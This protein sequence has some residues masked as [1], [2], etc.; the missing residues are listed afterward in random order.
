MARQIIIF[1]LT[2]E[3]CVV[4]M[5]LYIPLFILKLMWHVYCR[6]RTLLTIMLFGK[7][8]SAL[9]SSRVVRGEAMNFCPI[10]FLSL[11][12]YSIS[13]IPLYCSFVY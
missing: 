11:C 8:V 3:R 4:Y 9:L 1:V 2:L 13:T 12:S 6:I 10:T 5:C 7:V